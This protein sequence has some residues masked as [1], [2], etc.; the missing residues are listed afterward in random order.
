MNELDKI[1]KQLEQRRKNLHDERRLKAV[2]VDIMSFA[3]FCQDGLFETVDSIPR[4]AL[5]VGWRINNDRMAHFIFGHESFEI[6]D[7]NEDV[8]VIT[9]TIKTFPNYKAKNKKDTYVT[10]PGER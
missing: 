6:L 9:P 1:R 2:A 8:P 4:D 5:L 10:R 3:M 7:D